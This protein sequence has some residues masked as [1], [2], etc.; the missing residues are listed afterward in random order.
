[1]VV[2]DAGELCK[3]ILYTRTPT[4]ALII[5]FH[6]F[7]PVSHHFLIS[8]ITV[9]VGGN[10]MRLVHALSVKNVLKF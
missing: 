1:M 7:R 8:P 5:H 4:H 2:G 3:G 10:E 9:S 6:I